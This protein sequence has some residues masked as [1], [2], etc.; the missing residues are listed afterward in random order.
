ME[1]CGGNTLKDLIDKGL[2]KHEDKVWGLFREI[3]Q[4]LNHIHEQGMIHRDLKPGNVLIDANGHAKIGDF[5]LATT[6]L[7]LQKESTSKSLTN[8][9]ALAPSLLHKVN[10][11]SNLTYQ[12]GQIMSGNDS[13]HL[14]STS[15]SGAVGTALYVAPELLAPTTK[16]KFIY[17]QKVDIYSLGVMFYEMNFPFSTNM[18][19]IYVIQNLRHKDIIVST[20]LNVDG[21]EKQ[22]NLIKSMLNH[23]PNLRPSAKEMLLNESIPRKADEIALDEMLQ[24]SFS[25]KQST[26]YKKILKALFEQKNSK[27]EDASFDSLNCKVNA[28]KIKLSKK[29][30]HLN[31]ARDF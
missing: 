5:G 18:E 13:R 15:L 31:R 20:N 28:F 7:F 27:I 3:L 29:R 4:G 12:S 6:K 21:H 11:S 19:R 26:N 10:S 16:N 2:Y 14:D 24:Y 22:L 17:T 30:K 23:D 25:N 8:E 9:V 1:Y